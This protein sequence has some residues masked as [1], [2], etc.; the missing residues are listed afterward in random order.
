MMSCGAASTEEAFVLYRNCK[1]IMRKGGCNLRKWNSNDQSLLHRI[2]EAE[3]NRIEE[4]PPDS[5]DIGRSETSAAMCPSSL[6]PNEVNKI[7]GIAWHTVDDCLSLDL[8]P[9]IECVRTL[10]PKRSLLKLSAKIFDPSG[11][12]SLFTINIKVLH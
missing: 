7:L 8:H 2:N 5:K 9:V 11:C 6:P 1:D 3:G 12:L 4:K 10:K